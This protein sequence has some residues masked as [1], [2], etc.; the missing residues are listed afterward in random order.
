MEER[1]DLYETRK[2]TLIDT[3][4]SKPA[5]ITNQELDLK[6]EGMIE[7]NEELWKCKVCGKTATKQSLIRRHAE[8]HIDGV[9]HTCH[10]CSHTSST[11][12]NLR[13]HISNIH[14]ELFS[15]NICGKTGMNKGSFHNHKHKVHKALSIKHRFSYCLSTCLGGLIVD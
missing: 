2:G 4:D 13:N 8:T 6:I 7:K 5:I 9:L 12:H 11:R 1:A 14:S 15:C 10:I 3:D